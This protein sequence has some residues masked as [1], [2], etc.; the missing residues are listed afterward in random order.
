MKKQI[1]SQKAEIVEYNRL[2]EMIDKSFSHQKKY[3]KKLEELKDMKE[4]N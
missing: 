1:K 3:K 4:V 2:K